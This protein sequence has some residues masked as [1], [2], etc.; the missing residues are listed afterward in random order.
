MT[1]FKLAEAVSNYRKLQLYATDN[2]T[3]HDSI[4]SDLQQMLSDKESYNEMDFLSRLI[5]YLEFG[6]SYKKHE[7]LFRQILQVTSISFRDL[8]CLV[9][10]Q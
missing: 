3:I 6:L 9:N 5:V 1:N 8:D 10:K 7:K 2:L 4:I